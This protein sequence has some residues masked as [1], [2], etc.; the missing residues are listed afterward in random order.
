VTILYVE[1]VEKLYRTEK[2]LQAHSFAKPKNLKFVLAK[3]YF[4]L[5]HLFFWKGGLIYELSNNQVRY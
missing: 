5:G 3:A 1:I 4:N 2:T